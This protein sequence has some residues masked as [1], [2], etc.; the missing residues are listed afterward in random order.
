MSMQQ[1]SGAT[2]ER[3]QLA[4]S[5]LSAYHQ[6]A[7]TN[8]ALIVSQGHPQQAAVDYL[9][10]ADMPRTIARVLVKQFDKRY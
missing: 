3:E 1:T 4:P 10:A 8:A 2:I 6:A 5:G 7:L 9:V